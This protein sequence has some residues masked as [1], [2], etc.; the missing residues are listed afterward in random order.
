M[1]KTGKLHGTAVA[2]TASKGASK[3]APEAA[4]PS[5]RKVTKE[6]RWVIYHH[7]RCNISRAALDRLK[8]LGITPRV[9][10]YLKT[11]LRS[12]DLN[13]ILK[14][15]DVPPEAVVRKTENRFLDLELDVNPPR[16]IG[17]WAK[18]LAA[19]PVLIERPIISD[20]THAIL[21]LRI[22]AVDALVSMH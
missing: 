8:I 16:S 14:Q 15:L 2:K 21:G 5:K 22:E 9:I 12:Q 17:E 3:S 1:K 6:K 4:T 20:G 13:S 11:P 18:L 10:E 19:N 7:P